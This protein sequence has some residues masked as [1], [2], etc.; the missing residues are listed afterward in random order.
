MSVPP[1]QA[2]KVCQHFSVILEMASFEQLT[3][4]KIYQLLQQL[5]CSE[6]VRFV[7]YRFAQRYCHIP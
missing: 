3:Q 6:R 1:H 4:S 7:P 2:L 5:S